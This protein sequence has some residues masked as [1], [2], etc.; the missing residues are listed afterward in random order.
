MT[1]Y[2]DPESME[3]FR[4]ELT[5]RVFERPFC[6]V[7]LDEIEKACSEITRL[8]LQVLDDGRLMDANNREVSFKNAYVIMTTN[9]GNQVYKSIAAYM[10][11]E[12]QTRVDEDGNIV[13]VLT[14]KP[15]R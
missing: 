4:T 2:S 14:V 3:R 10:D 7:L 11:D 9:A 8:L 15:I 12:V 13:Y 5:N 1:E 6:I